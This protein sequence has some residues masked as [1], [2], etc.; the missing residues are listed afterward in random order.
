ME[1]EEGQTAVDGKPP[2]KQI[3]W[4]RKSRAGNVI[5]SKIKVQ[6]FAIGVG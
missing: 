1:T 2:N 3:H 5:I 4:M 6:V